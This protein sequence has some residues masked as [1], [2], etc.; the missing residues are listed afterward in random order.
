MNYRFTDLVDID[1]F[2]AML[3]SFYEATGILHGL[4]DDKNNVI[5]AIGWQDACV[6]FH[7]SSDISN[8]RCLESNRYLSE[9]VG[10]EGYVGCK[11]QNG[12]MDY[13]TPIVV[14]GRLLATLYFGQCLPEPPDMEFFRRQA[15]ECG[16]DEEAYL[17]SIRKLP[18]VPDA[19]V[20][21]IMAFYAQL[22]QML[23]RCGLDRLRQRQAERSLE[24]LNRDLAHRVEERT[25]ELTAR[26]QQLA[27]E[28]A[29]REQTAEAL[30]ASQGKLQALLDS[31]PIGI[32]WTIDGKVEY[33]NRKF[34]EMYGY[35]LGE[36][37]TVEDWYRR[38]YPDEAFRHNVVASW[39]RDVDA[40]KLAGVEAPTLEAPIVCKDGS[41]RYAII[42][43]SWIGDRRLVNFSD[44]TA[45]WL[46]EQRDQ[47]HNAI[48]GLIARGA[49]LDQTL[50]S[51]ASSVET[52]DKSAL[53]SILLIDEEGKRL[54]AG[55]APSLPD[56]YN[57]AINGVEI[58][59]GVGSCGTA[60]FTEQRVIVADIQTHPYWAAFKDLAHQA[61]LAS[62]WS[63]PIFSSKGR[64]LGTFAV[65][66]R[67]PQSPNESDI[68]RITRA[69]NLASI[70][71]ERSYAQIQLE[72]QAMTDFLTGLASRR[73]F[74]E[75]A[76]SALAHAKRYGEPFSLLMI[77]IDHFK[78]VNDAHGHKSGDMVLQGIARLMGQ[79]MREVDVVGRIGGEEFA[80]VLPNTDRDAACLA[81]ER[82]LLAVSSA[83][84]PTEAGK[85]L[86]MTISIGVATSADAQS[87]VE[88]LMKK[89]DQALYAAKHGGRNQVRAA[90]L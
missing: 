67:E 56:F 77:D 64:L 78:A 72:R 83:E 33:V 51:L 75:R 30:H 66:H 19:R 57:S 65:Y 7:R 10:T 15:Q 29:E 52:E 34:T 23:A 26:N 31:S 88:L 48:L 55:A 11:C 41:V 4:V 76:V 8:Q 59:P 2:Q 81:A 44:I 14:D 6:K 47:M 87:E 50:E 69:A 84:L 36:I 24:R 17:E 85:P 60:A 74:M 27:T 39:V 16:F 37:P 40:A 28:A 22:A 9:N 35:C 68:R 90:D 38:A 71:I 5:S 12:L 20:K 63:E 82:L 79:T 3:Q 25:A 80:I 73:C 13:A 49:P 89:A 45:R 58:G 42:S 18:V 1:A 62:C 46:A 54:N 86:R 61:G 32:G 70:A 21:S 43:V 53:C